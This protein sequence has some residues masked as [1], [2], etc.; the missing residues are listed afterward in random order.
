MF[1]TIIQRKYPN[2]YFIL[3]LNSSGS[4]DQLLGAKID[5]LECPFL[6]ILNLALFRDASREDIFFIKLIKWKT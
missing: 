4:G 1:L 2:F 6:S 5:V 3:P